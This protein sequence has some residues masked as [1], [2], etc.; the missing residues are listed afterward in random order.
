MCCCVQFNR[1]PERAALATDVVMVLA[2][3]L[4]CELLDHLVP[5]MPQM[6]TCFHQQGILSHLSKPCSGVYHAFDGLW[7]LPVYS[8]EILIVLPD[9]QNTAPMCHEWQMWSKQSIISISPHRLAAA[10]GALILLVV[11][12]TV[13][14]S[15]RIFSN[16][17][18]ICG[19]IQMHIVISQAMICR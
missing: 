12:P 13:I 4:A 14:K 9:S 19:L 15:M 1:M 6:L 8:L 2:C 3:N 10:Q 7:W 18:Q 11:E 16:S 5:G 17:A